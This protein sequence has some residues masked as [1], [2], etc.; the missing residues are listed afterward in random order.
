MF[1]PGKTEMRARVKGHLRMT[2]SPLGSQE[3]SGSGPHTK[4]RL[5]MT[6]MPD[7]TNTAFKGSLLAPEG[8]DRPGPFGR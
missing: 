5:A 8:S 6:D 4:V 3:W 2:L 1:P 7:A